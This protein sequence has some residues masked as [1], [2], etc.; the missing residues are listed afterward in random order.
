MSL[1]L[2][3]ERIHK[4][5]QVSHDSRT[6]VLAISPFPEHSLKGPIKRPVIEL[7]D[8]LGLLWVVFLLSLKIDFLIPQK[9]SKSL[10]VEGA[11]LLVV[12]KGQLLVESEA[13]PFAEAQLFIE[14]EQVVLLLEQL[15]I[16]L[17]GTSI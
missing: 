12:F 16:Y 4:E 11:H 2:K 15:V 3:V 7:C 17:G 6:E 5:V 1:V 13:F 10:P 14:Q 9:L 8:L